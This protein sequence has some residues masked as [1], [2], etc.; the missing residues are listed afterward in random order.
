MALHTHGNISS[1]KARKILRDKK[2]RGKLLS[3]KQKG[4][5]GA[6]ISKLASKGRKA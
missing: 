3:K 5:F 4:F 1:T 6:R 2:I